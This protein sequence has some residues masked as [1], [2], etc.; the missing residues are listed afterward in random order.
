MIQPLEILDRAALFMALALED[1]T[2]EASLPAWRSFQSSSQES[3]S[4]GFL[5]A[6]PVSQRSYWLRMATMRLVVGG[7][8]L[9]P[10]SPTAGLQQWHY[11]GSPSLGFLP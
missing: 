4:K 5:L 3:A 6:A 8:S 7:Y 9:D 1:L 2:V 11:A 10:T